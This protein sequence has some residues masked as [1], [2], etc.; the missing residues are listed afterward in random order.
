MK[1][2]MILLGSLLFSWWASPA[3]SDATVFR[4]DTLK[5][6]E[7][8]LL[9]S[10]YIQDGNNSAV[11][12]GIGTEKLTVYATQAKL[13]RTYKKGNSWQLQAG[14]DIISSASTDNIDDVVS[15]A[16][17]LDARSYLNADYSWSPKNKQWQM[18]AGTGISI[19]SDYLSFPFRAGTSYTSKDR[20]RTYSLGVQYFYDD[21][22]WGRI[23]KDHFRPVT[24][25]FP[26]ELRGQ[27]WFDT[28]LRRSF[29][30]KVGFTQVVNKRLIVGVFPEWTYQT[31]VLATPFHRVFFNDGSLRVER[32]PDRRMKLGLGLKANAF[33]G[34][35]T[36][37]NN[38]LSFYRDDFGIL[39]F[40]IEQE[41]NIKLNYLW[42]LMPFFRFY[43]QRGSKY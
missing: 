16:S 42:T 4:K 33:V 14:A 17:I 7:I 8:E 37:L 39:G 41:A 12:G 29:N 36:I 25:I 2:K 27:S 10:H 23:D 21:L 24:L 22:R 15:S 20:A 19:E 38:G 5:K 31:G 6:T 32:L 11:T 43:H 40:A 26:A 3:Q 30:A 9:Y 35:S 18:T 28:Y 34:G 13:K 1:R